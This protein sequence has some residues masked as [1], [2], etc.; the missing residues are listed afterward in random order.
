[1]ADEEQNPRHGADNNDG[2]NSGEGAVV[3]QHKFKLLP[4]LD[5]GDSL[6]SDLSGSSD[7]DVDN[8]EDEECSIGNPLLT[9]SFGNLTTWRLSDLNAEFT[10]YLEEEASKP[11]EK[12]LTK[13]ERLKVHSNRMERYM[14]SALQKYNAEEKLTEDMHFEFDKVRSQNWIVEGDQ[15]NQ[16][17]YHFNFS[18]TQACSKTCL[19]F[20]EVIPD[21]GDSFDITCC[22]PLNDDDS[23]HCYG[24]KNRHVDDLRH[25]ACGNVYVGGHEDQK[26]PFMID[27][28]SED[29]SD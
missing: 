5:D 8:D 29:D 25:P 11:K 12:K 17:Y 21:D 14:K 1:M 28:E 15:D 16:F 13:E 2:Q 27:T 9:D 6:P 19:F 18:A 26:F 4:L 10:K 22:K 24:C 23:G 7:G 3:P 20:A